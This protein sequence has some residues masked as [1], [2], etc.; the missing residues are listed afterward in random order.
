[1]DSLAIQIKLLLTV[2]VC[3]LSC[4]SNNDEFTV[5]TSV[6]VHIGCVNQHQLFSF[7]QTRLLTVVFLSALSALGIG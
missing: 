2:C 6:V 1:M 4:V 3:G 7:S 5:A